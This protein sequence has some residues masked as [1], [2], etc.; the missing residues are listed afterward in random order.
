MLAGEW[1]IS[2]PGTPAPKGSLKCVGRRGK[3]AHVVVEDNANTDP[4]RQTVATWCRKHNPGTVQK[5]DA[6]GVE[7]TFTVPRPASHYRTRRNP[8]IG[9]TERNG[10]RASAPAHPTTRTA[11]DVDKL[12]RLILDAL[13]DAT[14]IPDDSAVVELAARKAYPVTDEI[15]YDDRLAYPGV[16]IRLYPLT[17]DR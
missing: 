14:V 7:I 11:G 2:I 17:E 13:Q 1:S 16:L 6:L 5:G 3:R 10:L 12:V 8:T 9:V 15:G 4:W